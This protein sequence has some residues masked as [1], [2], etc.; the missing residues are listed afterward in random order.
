MAD[1]NLY[2]GDNIQ[3][4]VNANPTGTHFYLQAGTYHAQAVQPKHD[5]WFIGVGTVVMNGDATALFAFS[6]IP[7]GT[8]GQRV[9]L[10]NLEITNYSPPAR[11]AVIRPYGAAYDWV[12]EDLKVHTNA[13]WGVRCDN[14]WQMRRLRI[15]NN[16]VMGIGGGG[17]SNTILEDSYIYGNNTSHADSHWEAGGSK[18]LYASG[19]TVRNNFWYDNDGPGIWFDGNTNGATITGNACYDN[20]GPGIDWEINGAALIENNWTSNNGRDP[21]WA[22]DYDLGG[23]GIVVSNSYDVIIRGNR[24]LDNQ[25]GIGVGNANRPGYNLDN[26]QVTDN[27][28]RHSAR[29]SGMAWD[30]AIP[31]PSSIV[32]ANNQYQVNPSYVGFRYGSS[33]LTLAGWQGVYPLDRLY[34]PPTGPTRR[35]LVVSR[36]SGR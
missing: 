27:F 1:V 13:Q 20:Y 12:L 22:D 4:Q 7:G 15:Y 36:L 8:G 25:G 30:V 5:Q 24:C 16:G 9:K 28:I 14:G 19:M 35:L 11:D 32:W 23:S 29:K 2:P 17:N 34:V 3:A 18:F 10:S 6:G 31:D 26:V 21:N 33:F